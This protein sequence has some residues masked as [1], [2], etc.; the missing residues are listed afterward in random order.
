MQRDCRWRIGGVISQRVTLRRAQG[1]ERERD[2]GRIRGKEGG[3]EVE[4]GGRSEGM[5]EDII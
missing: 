3:R 2:I 5:E 1:G 4:R